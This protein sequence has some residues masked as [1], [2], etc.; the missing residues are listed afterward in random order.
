MSAFFICA[1]EISS[2]DAKDVNL[3]LISSNE[4]FWRKIFLSFLPFLNVKQHQFLLLRDK[5]IL[6][7]L[8]SAAHDI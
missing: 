7:Q 5:W 8:L 4:S 1:E 3:E 2:S 6:T